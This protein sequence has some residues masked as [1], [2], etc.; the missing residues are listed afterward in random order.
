M[1]VEHGWRSQSIGGNPERGGI[2]PKPRLSHRLSAVSAR[3]VLPKKNWELEWL[4]SIS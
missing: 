2:A 1:L 3:Y 4:E